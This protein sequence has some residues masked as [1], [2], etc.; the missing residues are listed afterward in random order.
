MDSVPPAIPGRRIWKVSWLTGLV[1]VALS[2]VLSYFFS[3]GSYTDAPNHDLLFS[4]P[5]LAG[6]LLMVVG[7]VLYAL[8]TS[9][10]P[11]PGARRVN[12]SAVVT[13]L[14][15][16]T[17]ILG[18]Y[19]VNPLLSPVAFLHDSDL[20]GVQDYSDDYPQNH[21]RIDHPYVSFWM[22]T[23][24]SFTHDEC[25]VTVGRGGYS[26]WLDA[27]A[28]EV[29]KKDNTTYLERTLLED[30]GEETAAEGVRYFNMPRTDCLDEGDYFLI[31][32]AVLGD[33][34]RLLIWG[35]T[36]YGWQ[37]FQIVSLTP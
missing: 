4:L 12:R 31:D 1:I 14:A 20:D 10:R 34:F 27:T 37:C 9:Q 36:D 29:L 19:L 8:W 6:L 3:M 33:G 13:S 22:H 15:L 2:I 18:V 32:R 5:L 21:S 25:N 26:F 17:V 35:L 28:I 24:H 30:L 11:K 16:A 23:S 7:A